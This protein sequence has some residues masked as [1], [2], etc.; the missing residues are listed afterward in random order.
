MNFT[1]Q[2]LTIH[3]TKNASNQHLCLYFQF[4][5]KFTQKTAESASEAWKE[6][7]NKHPNDTFELVWDCMDMNGFEISARKVWYDTLTNFKGRIAKV[8]VVSGNLMIRS[9]AK[10]MLKFFGITSEISR[11]KEELPESIRI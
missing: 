7:M 9:A 2:E 5:S 10:V 6:F 1:S 3:Q 8:H 11:S 4:T